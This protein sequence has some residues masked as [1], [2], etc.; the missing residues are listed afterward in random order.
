MAFR[1]LAPPTLP[2]GEAVALA[3]ASEAASQRWAHFQAWEKDARITPGVVAWWSLSQAALRAGAGSPSFTGDGWLRW[4]TQCGTPLLRLYLTLHPSRARMSQYAADVLSLVAAGAAVL[5][6]AHAHCSVPRTDPVAS[7]LRHALAHCLVHAAVVAGPAS[8]VV[9]AA[10]ALA[11]AEV[12]PLSLDDAATTDAWASAVLARWRA[13]GS[14][15]AASAPALT[16]AWATDTS[17]AAALA[18][19]D[20]WAN[21]TSPG[22]GGGVR[23]HCAHLPGASAAPSATPG[24]A[25]LWWRTALAPVSLEGDGAA[26][27]SGLSVAEWLAAL[28]LRH[29]VGEWEYP[30]LSPSATADKAAVAEAVALLKASA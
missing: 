3:L 30:P 29:E 6:Q 15:G 22:G 12:R 14:V 13:D 20:P 2:A 19:S 4:V 5:E 27:V 1:P 18:C 17:P 11:R 21:C 23:T 9:V 28:S 26:A 8:E 7:S 16:S 24:E 10:G 25:S